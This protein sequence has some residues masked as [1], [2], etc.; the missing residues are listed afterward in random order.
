MSHLSRAVAIA[1]ASLVLLSPTALASTWEAPVVVAPAPTTGTSNSWSP[2]I[3]ADA[4]GNL[5][6][7]WA[8]DGPSGFGV[9]T[10]SRTASLTGTW[11]A[12]ARLGATP[13][14]RDLRIAVNASGQAVA[15]WRDSF[16]TVPNATERL[17]AVTRTAAGS[18][19]AA[20]SF[21]SVQTEYNGYQLEIDAA[22]RSMG[23][24][25]N[26]AGAAFGSITQTLGSAPLLDQVGPATSTNADGG[27][28]FDLAIDAAGQ[29][30]VLY[31]DATG[32]AIYSATRVSGAPWQ[33][34]QLVDQW[35]AQNDA[36]RT[37]GSPRLAVNASGQAAAVW[38]RRDGGWY[39][40][41]GATRPAGGAW[42]PSTALAPV[43]IQRFVFTADVGIDAAGNATAVWNVFGYELLPLTQET[44]YWTE[45]RSMTASST[46][47]FAPVQI[48]GER[49]QDTFPWPD[50]SDPDDTAGPSLPAYTAVNVA[51][52][53]GGS[54]AVTWLRTGGDKVTFEGSVRRDTGAFESA[55]SIADLT[56]GEDIEDLSMLTAGV[57]D[58]AGRGT[59]LWGDGRKIWSRSIALATL[60][61]DPAPTDP[62]PSTPP[63]TDPTTPTPGPEGPPASGPPPVTATPGPATPISTPKP[64]STPTAKLVIAM[65][66]VPTGK[67]CPALANGTVAGVRTPLKVKAAKI[68][69]KL[70]CKV[71]GVIVLKAATKVGTKVDVLVTA[72][73]VKRK[74]VQFPAS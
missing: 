12:P 39:G 71:T 48:R 54:A 45:V 8:G 58:A 46:G 66:I 59:V 21:P 69:G 29:A 35:T 41:H 50:E 57:V 3:A 74:L 38:L 1:V 10:A 34:P 16:P 20:T 70:R 64:Q 23:V 47:A 13:S 60:P 68:R 36:D 72:K 42:R 6:A 30:T 43:T 14:P 37:L 62:V 55:T 25:S 65:Y 44:R 63:P 31:V 32:L 40:V 52:G 51:V 19:S 7:L 2:Q 53:S 49:L 18:W 27:T 73:G 4:K 26:D 56:P 17:V 28:P 24:W 5:T 67:K 22:G 33:A 61:S 11:S 9:Y 15:G